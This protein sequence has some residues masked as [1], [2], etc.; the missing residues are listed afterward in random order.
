MQIEG[1]KNNKLALFFQ[2]INPFFM[3]FTYKEIT[4]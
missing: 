1:V 3:L 2:V 4:A